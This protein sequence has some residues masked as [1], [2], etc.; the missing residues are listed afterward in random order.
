MHITNES[1]LPEPLY[2]AIVAQHQQHW[3]GEADI[4]CI[5]LID[6]PLIAWM[7]RNYGE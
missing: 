5:Q 1:N 7:W 6:A 3:V 2:Q 4:S